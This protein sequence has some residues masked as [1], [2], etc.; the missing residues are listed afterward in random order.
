LRLYEPKNELIKQS[1]KEKYKRAEVIKSKMEMEILESNY[2]INKLHT[3]NVNVLN[4]MENY[5][6]SY[7]KKDKRNFTGVYNKFKKYLIDK[8]LE[9]LTFYNLS[10]L[11]IEQFM[12]FLEINS[13]GEGVFHILKGLKK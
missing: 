11:L 3:K 4:W 7:H 6:A 8:N 1:N 13:K 5:I 10:P 12:T 2:E 9:N